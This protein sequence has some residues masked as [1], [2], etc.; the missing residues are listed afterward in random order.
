M[1]CSR[2]VSQVM[3]LRVYFKNLKLYRLFQHDWVSLF[4]CASV[5][6]MRVFHTFNIFLSYI[7][8]DFQGK[9]IIINRSIEMLLRFKLMKASETDTLRQQN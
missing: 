3:I 7:V 9:R 4:W 1:E 8:T 5:L 2:N 6:L